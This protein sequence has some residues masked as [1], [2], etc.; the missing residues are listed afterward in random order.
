[1][2]TSILAII[3]ALLPLLLDYLESERKEKPYDD[4]QEIRRDAAVG[5]INA[6]VVLD[7]SKPVFL[8][9]GEPA[10]AAGYWLSPG[11]M[12]DLVVLA[13]SAGN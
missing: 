10:P 7:S 12:A 4:A 5:D 13:E 9:K 3:A 6:L 1:M 8:L 11:A 2:T